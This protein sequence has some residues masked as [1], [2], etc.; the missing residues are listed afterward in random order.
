VDVVVFVQIDSQH[1]RDHFLADGRVE[2]CCV[3]VL[4]PHQLLRFCCGSDAAPPPF[5]TG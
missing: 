3:S 4:A 1:R 2:I 5:A